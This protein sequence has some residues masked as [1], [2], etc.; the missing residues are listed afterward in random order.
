MALSEKST[1]RKYIATNELSA[2]NFA[3]EENHDE[4]QKGIVLKLCEEIYRCEMRG[5]LRPAIDLLAPYW[6]G[7]GSKLNLKTLNK[8]ESA[9]LLLRSGSI[10]S[11]FGNAEQIKNS[12]E[13]AREFLSQA[14]EIFDDLG[15][16]EGKAQCQNKTG[17]TYW[18][19]G[20]LETAQIYFRESLFY[21]Q[22]DESKAIANLNLGMIESSNFRYS[23]ALKFYEQ[24][25]QF[26][27]RISVF[28]EAKIRN[29]I[30]LAY[31]NIGKNLAGAERVAYFDQAIIEFEG[32]LICYEE[33]HNSRSAILARNNIGFLYYSIELYDEALRVLEIAESNAR[34]IGDKNHL[35]VV[36]D[37][38]ARA[39][40]AR[41][42]YLKASEVAA[43]SVRF[44]ESFENSNLL[45][46]ALIT[47]GIA[48]AR[49]GEV[50]KAKSAFSRAEEVASF[51]QDFILTRAARLFALREMFAEYR[52]PDRL[53]DYLD[54]VKH[55][56]GNQEKDIIDALSDVA[57]KIEL[58]NKPI[59]PGTE[60]KSLILPPMFSLDDH[61][62]AVGHQYLE[63]ALREA[64][65]NQSRAAALLGMSRQKFAARVN[66]DFPDLFI[67]FGGKDKPV[68]KVQSSGLPAAFDKISLK[69]IRD[70]KISITEIQADYREI[71]QGDF[72]FVKPGVPETDS[73]VLIG[74][75]NDKVLKIGYFIKNETGCYLESAVG[76]RFE[77]G[78]AGKSRITGQVV[79]FCRRADFQSY[80]DGQNE[81]NYEAAQEM[82]EA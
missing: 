30:G 17:A 13:E 52:P 16:A 79:G 1:G 77:L 55:L 46:T 64:R 72:L 49:G 82:K 81:E 10:I 42:D 70:E 60:E 56:S 37:T 62:K 21:A 12:Q 43:E 28:T 3:L 44:L 9:N 8:I 76:D 65:G 4:F 27:G 69:K 25:Y 38:I 61:L 35:S 41:G 57:E 26:I 66:K 67:S 58:E 23:S 78:A 33:V 40:I 73:H 50:E 71:R 15:D 2:K 34:R 29:G 80:L 18:R 20:E 11:A 22:S 48:L 47:C 24:A 74:D 36:T 31:K 63:A 54:A 51:I 75:Q 68:E 45:A 7:F 19:N 53:A 5:D 14:E 39:L 32:A 59:I 6:Q